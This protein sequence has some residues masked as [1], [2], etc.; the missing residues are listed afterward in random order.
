ME[1][2]TLIIFNTKKNLSKVNNNSPK[3][4]ELII[5]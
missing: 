4:I 5:Y 2:Q 1:I 3:N